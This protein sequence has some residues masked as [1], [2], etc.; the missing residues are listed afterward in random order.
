MFAHLAEHAAEVH[1]A[2]PVQLEFFN[3]CPAGRRQGDGRCEVVTP[4]EMARPAVVAGV[5]GMRHAGWT[6]LA[7]R[8]SGRYALGVAPTDAQHGRLVAERFSFS[9][10]RHAR[11]RMR[12]RGVTTEQIHRALQHPDRTEPDADDPELTHAL[13]RLHRARGSSVLRVVYNHLASP[14]RVVTV[15]FD[16]RAG[17]AQP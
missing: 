16:R 2:G 15:Y 8:R 1:H 5:G 6:E 11:I 9:L 7:D 14:W 12:Q 10:T 4:R 13:K 17:R 3:G